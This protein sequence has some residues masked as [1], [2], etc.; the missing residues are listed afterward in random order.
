[1][2]HNT[3]STLQRLLLI[4]IGSM[5]TFSLVLVVILVGFEINYAGRIYPGVKLGRVDLSGLTRDEAAFL[6]AREY[7]Y[8]HNG[9]IVLRDRDQSWLATPSDLGL[10]FD[11]VNNAQQAYNL[12][13]VG[14]LA[15][16]FGYQFQA[17]YQGL[18]LPLEMSFD[19]RIGHHYLQ[20]IAAQID[21]PTIEASLQ[22]EGV[23]VIVQSGQI[24]RHLDILSTTLAIESLTQFMIDGEITLVVDEDPPVI[25][26]VEA[27]AAVARRILSAP[28]VINYP[29]ATE[30]GPGPWAFARE[31]LA[32]MLVI[33]RAT[34]PEGD[35]YQ[36]SISNQRLHNFLTEVAPDLEKRAQNARF[37]FNDETRQLDLIE[38]AAYGQ[39]VDFETTIQT[40]NQ[41]VLAGE[42]NVALDMEYTAP[43]IGDDVSAE[44]L[45]ITE[46]VSS[47]TTYYYGSDTSR[48]QNIST[49]AG[50]FHGIL[51]APGETFSM[52]QALGDV[53][54]DTGYAEAWIIYGDRTI[55]G[56][57]GGVCQVS[58]T[59]FRTV[60][61]GGYPVAERH[62]HA[63]RVYYY[64]QTYG[65]GYDYDWAG[66]DATVYVPVV[67][68]KF[69]NDTPYW[70][71]METY[72]GNSYLT[73]K[74][75][76]TSDGRTIDWDTSGLT[77]KQDPP[78]PRY[79]V[80][81]DLEKGEIKQVDWSVEGADITVNR[82][83][84]RN[85]EAID[86]DIFTTYYMPWRAV[87]EYGP[88]TPGMPPE[89]PDPDNPCKPDS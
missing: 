70:L 24:G 62:P 56:V 45:G 85:G 29:G 51:I 71:L 36:V 60:F 54:L 19:Q 80:N 26:D 77:N 58:T 47:H 59:L 16:R 68:F 75:Y 86:S 27:Q 46:L 52:A 82:T 49:A 33:E 13:R 17:W 66:L 2:S 44:S 63:Y 78:E 61:F 73:W 39:N 10:V 15:D 6:L 38:P 89:D 40:I 21:I 11:A 32:E 84:F 3:A 4:V 7:N 42:H 74:F 88:G 23:D 20:N 37:I 9:K 76:S 83:V 55:K 67:D 43:E 8:T 41:Q 50:R 87:C 48:R 30:D 34:T 64:E 31:D 69:T 28:L 18:T 14:S 35:E 5:I 79:E 81:E 72:F 12:G 53:S 22:I 65:G 25:M 57:G 1:M